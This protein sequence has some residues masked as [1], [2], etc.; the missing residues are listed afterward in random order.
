MAP[1]GAGIRVQIAIYKIT[2]TDYCCAEDN[3]PA[4]INKLAK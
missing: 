4:E 2:Q 1:L 3:A